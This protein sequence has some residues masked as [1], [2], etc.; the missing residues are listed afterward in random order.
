M[1]R[2]GVMALVSLLWVVGTGAAAAQQGEICADVGGVYQDDVCIYSSDPTVSLSYPVEA[3]ELGGPAQAYTD[4]LQQAIEDYRAASAELGYDATPI[5]WSLEN[6]YEII[7]Y[8]DHIVT[9]VFSFW[10]YTGGAN[11]SITY[12]TVTAATDGSG[13]VYNL[14][15]IVTTS[16]QA[17]GLLADVVRVAVAE[18]LTR[19]TGEAYTADDVAES[20]PATIESFQHIALTP[21]VAHF[22]YGRGEVAGG[23]VGP[24]EV[25]VRLSDLSAILK[26]PFTVQNVS[27]AG[28]PTTNQA[29]NPT[30]VN[31]WTGETRQVTV[32]QGDHLAKLI[33]REYGITDYSQIQIIINDI[34]GLNGLANAN[35]IYPG[36]LLTVPVR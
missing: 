11:G 2:I 34:I 26:S 18:E 17:L 28:T 16:P 14:G 21:T 8:N 3:V 23:A 36:Q 29:A 25:S 4:A 20:L 9:V 15:D 12:D 7:T 1:K 32:L 19:I 27:P 35:V 6:G 33:R 10:M 24:V 22:Y 13:T 31:T 5:N 30:P